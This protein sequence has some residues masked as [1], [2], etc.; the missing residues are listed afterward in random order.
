[1]T[2]T[3]ELAR[4]DLQDALD[5]A[6]FVEDEAKE[7]YDELAAQMETHHTAEA[8]AFFHFM[9]ANEAKHGEDLAARRRQLFGDAPARVDR[10][11]IWDIEAPEYENVHAFMTLREALSVAMAA[12]T[13]AHKF[14]TDALALPV[15]DPVRTLFLELQEEEVHHQALVG[16]ELAKLPPDEAAAPEE[17][18]DEP[19]SQ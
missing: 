4:L 15:S 11:M 3:I 19:V 9:S 8:A 2:K 18:A 12:E 10:S 16:R 7:R 14:F 1:M 13:K 6:I 17:F 5:L